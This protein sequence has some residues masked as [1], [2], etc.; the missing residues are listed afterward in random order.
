MTKTILND[1][2]VQIKLLPDNFASAFVFAFTKQLILNSAPVEVL[3]FQQEME[4]KKKE[5]EKVQEQDEFQELAQDNRQ[6]E[7]EMHR[8]I[9]APIGPNTIEKRK[10][11]QEN[12][13]LPQKLRGAK[14]FIPKESLPERFNYLKPTPTNTDLDLGKLNPFLMDPLVKTIECQGEGTNV[15]VRG[16]VGHKKTALI[17]TETEIK[18]II[19]KF[20]EFSKIPLEE[21]YFKVAVG[22]YIIMAIFSEVAGSKFLIQKITSFHR[23]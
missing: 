5:L 12:Q 1:L 7:K 4:E 16:A 17:L 19:Q 13:P 2:D 3:K 18:N 14:L 15:L 11:V 20:S 6:L 10:M 23:Y 22:R 8:E 9:E 21:G